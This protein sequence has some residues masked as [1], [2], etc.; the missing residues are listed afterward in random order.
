MF[1]WL[2]KRALKELDEAEAYERTLPEQEIKIVKL[3]PRRPRDP[4]V[5]AHGELL[6][7][8]FLERL[9]KREQED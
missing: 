9:H 4:D 7:K 2:R 8:A 5:L 1:G 6:R 3:P